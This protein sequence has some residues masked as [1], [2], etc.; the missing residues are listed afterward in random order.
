MRSITSRPREASRRSPDADIEP[1]GKARDAAKPKRS[2]ADG[3]KPLRL[4]RSLL[5]SW[6]L[7]ET[8]ESLSGATAEKPVERIAADVRLERAATDAKARGHF[9][10]GEQSCQRALHDIRAIGQP[11]GAKW[12]AAK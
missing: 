10:D 8:I 5:L 2:G 1:S 7:A 4:G 12:R 9:I 11:K 6:P 3:S